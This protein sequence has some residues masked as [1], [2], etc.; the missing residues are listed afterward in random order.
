MY[1]DE[2]V[3][4]PKIIKYLIYFNMH[5]A[6]NQTYTAQCAGTKSTRL[7]S[8]FSSM[9]FCRGMSYYWVVCLIPLI[10]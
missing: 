8:S 1:D 3:R 7:D 4:C 10:S 2:S 6:E 9:S 5:M